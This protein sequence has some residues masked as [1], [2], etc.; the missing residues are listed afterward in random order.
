M[1][2]ILIVLVAILFSG[3]LN[4]QLPGEKKFNCFTILVGKNAS[5]TGDVLVAHN[6]DDWGE[7]IVNW[8]MVPAK[9]GKESSVLNFK[10]GAKYKRSGDAAELF[11]LEMPG[12]DFADCFINEH[13][14]V[15]VSNQCSSKEDKGELNEGGVAYMLR[16]IIAEKARTAKEG[17]EVAVSVLEKYGYASSGRTYSIAD[18]NEIWMLSVVRGKHWVAQMVPDDEVVIIPNYYTIDKIDFND[19][20]NFIY[21]KDIVEYATQR[22][23]YNPEKDGE[24]SFSNAYNKLTSALSYT[25]KCRKWVAMNILSKKKYRMH[26]KMPWSFKPEKKVSKQVLMKILAD[27]YEGTEMER[28]LEHCGGDPHRSNIASAI[29]SSHTQISFVA[30][31]RSD[32]PVDI[33]CCMWLAPKRPCLQ[34]FTPWYYGMSKMPEQLMIEDHKKALEMHYQRGKN[35]FK[36]YPDHAFVKVASYT[37]SKDKN[38]SSTVSYKKWKQWYEYKLMTNQKVFEGE[39]MEVY[40]KDPDKAR[41]MMSDYCWEC[42]EGILKKIDSEFVDK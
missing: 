4:A 28:N 36:Q 3:I 34:P 2:K 13:G 9:S 22:G 17:V 8:Y 31:L 20:D 19:S 27:H 16:R 1:K 15:V 23:W 21:S 7:N 39:L 25:N 41:K 14:V 24:F 5:A 11:W 26:D 37:N 40:K 12:M 6:E 42:F 32:M 29:C 35:L 38:Y 10:N 18:R 30:E 33:G